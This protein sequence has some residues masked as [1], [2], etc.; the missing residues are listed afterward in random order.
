MP[1][2]TPPPMLTMGAPSFGILLRLSRSAPT[3]VP[4]VPA[5]YA[6][7]SGFV[8]A[9]REKSVEATTPQKRLNPSL[10]EVLVN[11]TASLTAN[12]VANRF[13][14]LKDRLLNRY[15]NLTVYCGCNLTLVSML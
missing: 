14:S 11:L 1:S 5:T 6:I 12:T 9:I 3:M 2:S 7:R 10:A 15:L 8:S 4:R 13:L